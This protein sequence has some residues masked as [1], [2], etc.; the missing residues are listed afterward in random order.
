MTEEIDDFYIQEYNEAF[1]ELKRE[2]PEED[3]DDVMKALVSDFNKKHSD[4]GRADAKTNFIRAF[5]SVRGSG[6]SFDKET[7]DFLDYV[8]KADGKTRGEVDEW[9]KDA[10]KDIKPK[11]WRR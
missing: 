3:Y 9:A 8:Q 4:D 7:S 11:N 2:I 1:A 5:N 10:L 6:A